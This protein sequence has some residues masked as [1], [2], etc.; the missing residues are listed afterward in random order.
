MLTTLS[1]LIASTSAA[2]FNGDLT[3]PQFDTS[4]TNVFHDKSSFPLMTYAGKSKSKDGSTQFAGFTYPRRSSTSYSEYSVPTNKYIELHVT[5][6]DDTTPD[7]TYL[8]FKMQPQDQQPHAFY[9]KPYTQEFQRLES[10]SDG[11]KSKA[12]QFS[13]RVLLDLP[14]LQQRFDSGTQILVYFPS[15]TMNSKVTIDNAARTK[16][17]TSEQIENFNEAVFRHREWATMDLFRQEITYTN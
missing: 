14:K 12:E 10:G 17:A 1:I 8:K 13:Y 7:S 16:E 15:T 11:F 3:E 4:D 9:R 2:R 5:T 6:P